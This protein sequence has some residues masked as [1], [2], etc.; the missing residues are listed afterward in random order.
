MLSR[1][2]WHPQPQILG[3]A[4]TRPASKLRTAE[5]R[6]ID[7]SGRKSAA[8]THNDGAIW[9]RHCRQ[10][11]RL[12]RVMTPVSWRRRRAAVV[13]RM[14][15]VKVSTYMSRPRCRGPVPAPAREAHICSGACKYIRRQSWPL[16]HS[17]VYANCCTFFQPRNRRIRRNQRVRPSREARPCRRTSCEHFGARATLARTRQKEM[18][19]AS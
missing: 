4:L 11:K 6:G 15:R 5:I 13:G 16:Q 10:A 19:A 2:R 14:P 17:F 1:R 8:T 3:L 9:R 12:S 18:A 7:F